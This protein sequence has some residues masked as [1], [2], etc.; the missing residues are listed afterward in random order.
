MSDSHHEVVMRVRN[1]GATSDLVI[2]VN[3][4]CNTTDELLFSNISTNSRRPLEWVRV[5]EPHAGVALI[6]GSG[7]SLADCV[8]DIQQ[9]QMAGAK[10]FALNG[11]AKF[12]SAH[13][14]LPDFQVIVDAREETGQLVGSANEYLFA[15][16]VHPSLFEL[17]APIRVWHQQIEGMEDYFPPYEGA[18]ALIGGASAVGVSATCLAFAMGY[19][20]L[21]C[22]GL[23]SSHQGEASHAFHQSLNDA[24]PVTQVKF[25]GKLYN[26]SFTMKSQAERFMQ[27]SAALQQAGVRIS[28]HGSGLLP[29]MFHTGHM[30]ERAKY[31]TMWEIP[32][33]R[34]YSPGETWAAYFVEVVRPSGTIADFGCG[35]GRG[36]LA[37]HQLTDLP[38]TLLD[39]TYN[40]RDPA[41]EVL[42]FE[43][44]D[45]SVGPLPVFVQYGYCCDVMEHIPPQ[46]V[47]GVISNIM[48]ACQKGCFFAISTEEDR[49]GAMIGQ[50]LHLTVEPFGWW[51]SLLTGLGYK[52]VWAEG[53]GDSA[54]F[55]VE[56]SNEHNQRDSSTH[57]HRRGGEGS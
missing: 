8:D 16:Q 52:L 18:Y 34:V 20:E 11:A 1:P 54:L 3:L 30:E 51:Y 53:Q 9:R 35:T 23:D 29:D 46:L 44:A 28:V 42:P 4:V 25:N 5:E 14:V 19:R 7:P 6:C 36:G 15:S 17:A 56:H 39:F 43:Y 37:I 13:G 33:Y 41:A 21:H 40:S 47:V 26:A 57:Q 12:L 22:F 2:P 48:D 27:V 38:V 10:I 32:A 49:C 45:L 31:E 50:P 24:E 55:Y